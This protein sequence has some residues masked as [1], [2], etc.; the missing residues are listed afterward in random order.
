MANDLDG[1][2][3]ERLTEKDQ[4]FAR[5]WASNK[6]TEEKRALKNAL[7]KVLV[8]LERQ[9]KGIREKARLGK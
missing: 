4:P 7:F 8:K 2:I 9:I 5:K 6:K 1:W 3:E